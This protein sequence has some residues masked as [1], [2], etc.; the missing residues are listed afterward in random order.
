MHK[1]VKLSCE[2]GEKRKELR[3]SRAKEETVAVAVEK[4]LKLKHWRRFWDFGALELSLILRT[5]A[6]FR[7]LSSVHQFSRYP[8]FNLKLSR[9]HEYCDTNSSNHPERQLSSVTECFMAMKII[10]LFRL[11]DFMLRRSFW[12]SWMVDAI[13]NL[14]GRTG[15]L[16]P[17]T[18]RSGSPITLPWVHKCTATY[19][20]SGNDMSW[21]AILLSS[22][23]LSLCQPYIF[24]DCGNRY[25]T[26]EVGQ[27][28]G[29][30]RW[31]NGWFD[32]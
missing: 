28:F 2:N 13:Q 6:H 14:M 24:A 22:R 11:Y 12:I 19:F 31:M 16:S 3:E 23:S 30:H 18:Q 4:G 17:G 5:L 29:F 26:L 1:S 7:S 8:G 32:G 27:M 10:R 25:L 20:S 15:Q 21:I 9:V